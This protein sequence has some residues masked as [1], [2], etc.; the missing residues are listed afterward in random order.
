MLSG[1]MSLLIAAGDSI[2]NAACMILW[3]TIGVGVCVL[4]SGYV[5]G[6]SLAVMF[7]KTNDFIQFDW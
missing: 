1:V 3:C 6:L 2:Y 4:Y 7:R 5:I